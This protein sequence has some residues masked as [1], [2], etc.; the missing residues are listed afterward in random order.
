MAAAAGLQVEAAADSPVWR[1]LIQHQQSD[2]DLLI[3]IAERTSVGHDQ[4]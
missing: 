3:E 4:F 2:L 1:R